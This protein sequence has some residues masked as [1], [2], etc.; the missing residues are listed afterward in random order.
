MANQPWQGDPSLPK[1]GAD[2]GEAVRWDPSVDVPDHES[3]EP[4]PQPV[5]VRDARSREDPN[6]HHHFALADALQ[7][8][9]VSRKIPVNEWHGIRRFSGED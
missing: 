9:R 2:D 7:S 6:R 8:V 5:E 3:I 1:G 4:Q